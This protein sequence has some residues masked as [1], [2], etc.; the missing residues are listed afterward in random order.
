MASAVEQLT[1]DLVAIESVNPDLVPSGSGETKIAKFVASWLRDAGLEVEIVEPVAGRPSVVGVLRGSGGRQSLMLNAHMDT[2]GAGGMAR[3]FEPVVTDGRIY[4]RGA[5]DMK[6][7]LAAIMVAAR[8]ARKLGLKGDVIV[9][10]VAD[11]EVASLGTSA[12]LERFRADAAIVTEPTEL[13][14]CL[15]HKGFAWLEVETRGVAA[16]G[17]R[18]DAGVDAIAR[19]GRILSGIANLDRRL[20]AG[21]GHRLLGRGS[22]HASLIEGGQEW[23]TYPARCVVKVER[24]T[25]PGEDGARALS[26]MEALIAIAR[27]ENP[28][29]EASAKMV[30]E[31]VPSEVSADH[32]LAIAVARAAQ[33]AL[34]HSPEV[35]GV[36]YWMDMALTNAASIPTVAFGPIGEG[37]HSD[38]EWVDLA[39]LETCVHVYS[40]MA[41][42]I[43]R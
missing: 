28:L 39:S 9:T 19:T 30:L 14:L 41:E 42:L 13:R 16:H 5:Y 37:A 35:I 38:V 6:G 3:A 31:R 34:G 26:E 33:D 43:C 7:S 10:A 22:V 2:V 12:V 36:A 21:A 24:R 29:L 15:A 40:R 1:C 11:E 32:P 25:I 4:A 8:E 17:S 18:A 23:S 20:H 27:E